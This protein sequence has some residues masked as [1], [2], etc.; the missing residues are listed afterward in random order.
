MAAAAA[1]RAY[2]ITAL[3]ISELL[4]WRGKGARCQLASGSVWPP[5][6]HPILQHVPVLLESGP[7]ERLGRLQTASLAHDRLAGY[8]V[9]VRLLVT[10]FFWRV[11]LSFKLFLTTEYVSPND[12]AMVR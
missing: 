1:P 12:C 9:S 3:M 8:P 2:L 5:R 11:V 7:A 10:N 4:G 6:S